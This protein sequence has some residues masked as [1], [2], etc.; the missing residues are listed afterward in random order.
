LANREEEEAIRKEIESFNRQIKEASGELGLKNR[1]LVKIPKALTLVAFEKVVI[2][3]IRGNEIGVI[4]E[5]LCK[6]LS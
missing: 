3:D 4:E 6:N 1:K 2:L 5:E